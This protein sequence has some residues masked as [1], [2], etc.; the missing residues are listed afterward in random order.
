MQ[1][2]WFFVSIP[3]VL[4]TVAKELGVFT[5]KARFASGKATTNKKLK[6]KI[7]KLKNF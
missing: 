1:S 6:N 7:D 5:L 2:F 4:P 3:K